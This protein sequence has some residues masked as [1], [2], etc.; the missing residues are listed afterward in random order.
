MMNQGFGR[1]GV[2]PRAVLGALI[3]KHKN[4][5][6]DRGTILSIQEIAYP[7]DSNLL[8]T[9]RK[10]AEKMI[11]KLYELKG[12]K[13]VKPRTYRKELDQHFLNYSKKKRKSKNAQ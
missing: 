11:D 8:N 5:L 9:S 12:K 7:T 13:G 4:K 1:P 3:I 2:S 10:N 6:D